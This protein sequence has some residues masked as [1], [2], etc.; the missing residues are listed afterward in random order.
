MTS[1]S[2]GYQKYDMTSK[3][4]HDFK[5]TSWRQKYVMTSKY[6]TISKIRHDVKTSVLTS[7]MLVI[8]LMKTVSWQLIWLDT[9]MVAYNHIWTHFHQ[10]WGRSSPLMGAIMRHIYQHEYEIIP[11]TLEVVFTTYDVVAITYELIPTT[12]EVFP[13]CLKSLTPSTRSFLSMKVPT[14]LYN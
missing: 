12:F 7:N 9:V 2:L 6:V 3:I 13:P 4:R 11:A 10:L 8:I 14:T 1:E 5:N